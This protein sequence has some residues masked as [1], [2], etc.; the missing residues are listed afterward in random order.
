M[1]TVLKVHNQFSETHKTPERFDLF[2]QTVVGAVANLLTIAPLTKSCHN[3][4][5]ILFQYLA[6]NFLNDEVG[7]G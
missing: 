6:T 1:D 7:K 2:E 4:I 5:V 3:Y